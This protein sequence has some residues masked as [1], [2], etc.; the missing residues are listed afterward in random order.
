MIPGTARRTLETAPGVALELFEAGAG[1]PVI[2]LHGFPELAYSWRH[3]VAPLAAAGFRVIVPN[4]RGYG[5]SAAPPAI[6]DYDIE[7]LAGDV[8]AI[9][10]W[11]GA[12]AVVIGHDWGAPVAWHTALRYPELVRA[13]GSLSVPHAARAPR[14]PLDLMREAAGPDHIHYID[15]FQQPGLAEAE[16]EADVRAGLAGFYW[17]ISGDAPAKSASAPFPAAAASSIR[18]RRP[19]P[20]RPGSRKPTS[21]STSMPSPPAAFAAGSTGTA[22]STG[23]GN[24]PPTSRAPSSASPPSSSPAR[25]TRPATRPPSTGS[26]RSSP[27]F[28][29]SPSSTAAA[30]GPS[31]SGLPRSPLSCANSCGRSTP[32]PLRRRSPAGN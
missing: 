30:T 8:A 26:A 13:V 27:T 10:R 23:T 9:V 24:A 14:P 5:A 29:S 20:C 21:R 3:Q 1:P 31:R 22:T 25:A 11:A 16:F 6:E 4:Q 28:A 7:A 15:Y 19:P 2:L 32:D 12:P 17:S 18:S